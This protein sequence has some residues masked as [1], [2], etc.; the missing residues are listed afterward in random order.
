MRSARAVSDLRIS[1]EQHAREFS[2][3]QHMFV[4]GLGLRVGIIDGDAHGVRHG[5]DLAIHSGERIQLSVTRGSRHHER[6]V[7]TEITLQHVQLGGV[8]VTERQRLEGSAAQL[9]RAQR[10]REK[11]V[12]SWQSRTRLLLMF[13]LFVQPC[14]R[15]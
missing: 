5:A 1:C 8:G 12:S 10:H 9:K 3:S 14:P 15:K 7:V 11:A 13:L 6:E 4:R 2:V